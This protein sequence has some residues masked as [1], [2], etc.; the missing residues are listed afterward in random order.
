MATRSK[1]PSAADAVKATAENKGKPSHSQKMLENIQ[2]DKATEAR[3]KTRTA[4]PRRKATI[5]QAPAEVKDAPASEQPQAETVPAVQA[6]EPD[7]A[8]PAEGVSKQELLRQAKE[9]AHGSL[10]IDEIEAAIEQMAELEHSGDMSAELNR[11]T[12]LLPEFDSEVIQALQRQAVR[13][14]IDK[15]SVGL[16]IRAG[17]QALL[18]VEPEERI[19]MMRKLNVPKIGRPAAKKKDAA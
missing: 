10:K 6:T 14:G 13:G 16:V 7:Q 2:K 17:L 19:S 9:A 5:R 1:T 4:A 18:R 15:P 12:A 11:V 3:P 8:P